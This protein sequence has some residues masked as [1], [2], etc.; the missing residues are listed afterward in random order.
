MRAA[1][2][3]ANLHPWPRQGNCIDFVQH[4]RADRSAIWDC[5]TTED[6]L[7]RW[8]RNSTGHIPV[9][10][11]ASFALK[12]ETRGKAS[13]LQTF[14]YEGQV[15]LAIPP[16][17]LA[18]EFI[19]PCSRVTTCLSFQ[20][21]ASFNLFGSSQSDESDLWLIHSGFPQAGLGLFEYDGFFRHW[22]QDIGALAAHLEGRPRKPD[23]YGLVG[24]QFVGGAPGV[25]LLVAD[26]IVGSPAQHAGIKT[27]DIINAVDGVPLASLDDFHDWIDN[28]SPGETGVLSVNGQETL[29][30][31]EDVKVARQRF[32]IRHNTEWI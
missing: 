8:L 23:P 30:E 1:C 28:R 26:A 12:W 22:R 31:I 6:G 21:Q 4:I 18:V 11:G 13:G 16:K 25:G 29:V 7:R 10:N 24:L 3:V 14:S 2:F 17:L 19:L 9:T 15:N 27:G 5:L 20:I 32:A